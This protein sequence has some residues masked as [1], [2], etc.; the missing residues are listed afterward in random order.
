MIAVEQI[1]TW[2]SCQEDEHVE[3]K[4]ARQTFSFNEAAKYCAALA[5]EGGGHLVFGISPNQ[6][7]QVVGSLAFGDLPD[8]AHRLL[9]KLR[10]RIQVD[11]VVHPDGRVVVFTAPSRPTG[12]PV[13]VD[14]RY[15]MRAGESLTGMTAE[16]LERIFAEASP[17]FSAQDSGR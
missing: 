1:D 5:N 4:S 13:Q 16:V 17:D 9:Q 7:R 2:L 8:T 10:L 15:L 3:F 6:P 14:G 12:T 11:E